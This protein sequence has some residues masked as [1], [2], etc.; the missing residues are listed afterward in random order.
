VPSSSGI[1]PTLWVLGRALRWLLKRL[2]E[3]N[4]VLCVA[5]VSLWL[6][7]R[8]RPL[9]QQLSDPIALV[10]GL[11]GGVVLY[12]G[13]L[14]FV[15][16]QGFLVA[17]PWAAVRGSLGVVHLPPARVA[18]L[19]VRAVYEEMFWRGT[20]QFLLGNT[21]FGITATAVL[22]TL[23]HVYLNWINARVLRLRLVLEFVLFALVLSSTYAVSDRLL[24]VVGL[25]WA[26]NLL[27]IASCVH[28]DARLL[29]QPAK[30][31]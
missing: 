7:G 20:V 15:Q 1:H 12:F 16:S 11:M 29:S 6:T 10:I 17:K 23:R 28:R 24:L 19:G 30:P 27:I 13:S 8:W 3:P 22:F 9:I 14:S 18:V 5:L 31:Q 26:R 25:H 4:S 21:F 2:L